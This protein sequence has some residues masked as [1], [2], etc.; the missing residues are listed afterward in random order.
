MQG[1]PFEL[2]CIKREI[3]KVRASSLSVGLTKITIH[4]SDAIWLVKQ[5]EKLQKI[6][7]AW[8]DFQRKGKEDSNENIGSLLD[9]R[10]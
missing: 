3:D 10:V 2:K 9:V 7:N 1:D 6:A 4:T 5:V 8:N